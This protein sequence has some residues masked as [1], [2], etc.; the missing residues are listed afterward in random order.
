MSY[1]SAEVLVL[2]AKFS[3]GQYLVPAPAVILI[4]LGFSFCMDQRAPVGG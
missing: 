4:L 3:R 2:M 1:S